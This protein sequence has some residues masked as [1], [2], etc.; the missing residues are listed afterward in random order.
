MNPESGFRAGPEHSSSF[1][2]VN[3][4]TGSLRRRFTNMNDEE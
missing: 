1:V 3:D 2:F 4:R